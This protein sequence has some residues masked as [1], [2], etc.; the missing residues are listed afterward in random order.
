MLAAGPKHKK[1]VGKGPV[2]KAAPKEYKKLDKGQA[3]KTEAAKKTATKYFDSFLETKQLPPFKASLLKKDEFLCD[4]GLYQEFAT[5]L[6]DTAL[7]VKL[8]RLSVDNA[9][10]IFGNIVTMAQTTFSAHHTFH[11][12]LDNWYANTR[13]AIHTKIFTRLIDN[14]DPI[15]TKNDKSLSFELLSQMVEVLWQKNDIVSIGKASMIINSYNAIGRGGEVAFSNFRKW[16]HCMQYN[17]LDAEWSERKTLEGDHMGFFAHCMRPEMCLLYHLSGWL[18]VRGPFSSQIHG[19]PDWIYPTIARN[20]V[21]A[22]DRLTDYIREAMKDIP[23]YAH[24]ASEVSSTMLR[25]SPAHHVFEHPSLKFNPIPTAARGGWDM[26]GIG[27][28][29]FVYVNQL[30]GCINVAGK[31]LAGV[32]DPFRPYHQPM[33]VF[34]G[35]GATDELVQMVETIIVMLYT[36]VVPE[37]APGRR[38]WQVGQLFFAVELMWFS[39]YMIKYKKGLRIEKLIETCGRAGLATSRTELIT[40]ISDWGRQVKTKFRLDNELEKVA[41]G[42]Q[43]TKMLIDNMVRL[44]GQNDLLKEEVASLRQVNVMFF[45]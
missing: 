5:Y 21:T 29:V 10:G 25:S 43:P 4:K 20:P 2:E 40:K 1:T 38:L 3:D 34:C 42:H 28:N 33:L 19:E 8:K 31:I 37:I 36:E 39:D 14:G 22:A 9:K 7:D 45:S 17:T 32:K 24:R 15:D 30:L 41:G 16:S 23:E 27:G 35:D 26:K 6:V 11:A 18:I 13:S 12:G 44:Q